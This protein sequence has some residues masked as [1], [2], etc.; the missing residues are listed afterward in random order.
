M[1]CDFILNVEFPP[2]PWAIM[3]PALPNTTDSS[4]Y[5]PRELSNTPGAVNVLGVIWSESAA[6]SQPWKLSLMEKQEARERR[7]EGN[8]CLWAAAWVSCLAFVCV[9][10]F[11]FFSFF[12]FFSLICMW[13]WLQSSLWRQL[14][15]KARLIDPYLLG[16]KL[17]AQLHVP[18]LLSSCPGWHSFSGRNRFHSVPVTDVSV[19]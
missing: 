15:V 14:C 12:P 4:H 18:T 13:T 19:S 11:S 2:P 5:S 1:R 8:E 6:V 7:G 9:C 10:V 17:P 3:F 16:A